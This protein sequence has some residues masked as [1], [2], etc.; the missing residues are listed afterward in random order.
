M[1]GPRPDAAPAGRPAEPHL[2]PLL[3]A[4]AE[5]TDASEAM[6][7]A[8]RRRDLDALTAACHRA[9]ELTARV[10]AHRRALDT[11]EPTDGQAGRLRALRDRLAAAA[12][13]N[14][15]LI[16]QAW[17]LDAATLRL[18]AGFGRGPDGGAAAFY[19]VLTS[20]AWLDR[21]A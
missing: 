21:Q 8:V 17:A 1:T 10:E 20:S 11:V 15:L 13:R 2:G 14:A 9:Q 7:D 16:E 12:R 18:I 4:L 6:A 19:A 5:L 3:A